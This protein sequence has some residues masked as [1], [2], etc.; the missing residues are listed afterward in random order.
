MFYL[1]IA[2]YN[3]NTSRSVSSVWLKSINIW[4]YWAQLFALTLTPCF[5]SMF[6]T[7]PRKR[8]I[9]VQKSNHFN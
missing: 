8:D 5:L 1:N 6:S 2:R 3:T 7:F 4:S 9:H